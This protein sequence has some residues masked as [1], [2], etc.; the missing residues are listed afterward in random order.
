MVSAPRQ[1][2]SEK[3]VKKEVSQKWLVTFL[4]GPVFTIES[5]EDGVLFDW[6]LSFLETCKVECLSCLQVSC[7]NFF[8]KAWNA[9]FFFP[10]Q[11]FPH[12]WQPKYI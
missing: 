8:H 9:C 4:F 7:T 11:M 12:V 10:F 1:K 3:N 2:V 5:C 6:F